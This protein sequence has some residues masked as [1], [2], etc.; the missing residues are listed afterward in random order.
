M[1]GIII[2]F[3]HLSKLLGVEEPVGVKEPGDVLKTAV[4]TTAPTSGLLSTAT[5]VTCIAAPSSTDLRDDP[6]LVLREFEVARRGN[7]CRPRIVVL[8]AP[9]SETDSAR[10]N[11]ALAVGK[12]DECLMSTSIA[13]IKLSRF[14]MRKLLPG[15]WLHDEI[16]NLYFELILR[17]H[18][19]DMTLRDAMI[20]AHTSSSC[21]GPPPPK[22]DPIHIFTTF[23]WVKL[24]QV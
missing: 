1:H 21:S 6:H 7:S 4:E 8:Q 22:I 24:N 9:L 10:V 11:D 20:A 13:G 23:F 19:A 17:R 14:D 16:M 12:D 3:F 18:K 2:I 15:V 5:V